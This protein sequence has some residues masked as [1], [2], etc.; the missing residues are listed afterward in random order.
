MTVERKPR[1]APASTTAIG[2]S[3]RR[4]VKN[5]VLEPGTLFH[6]GAII[7]TILWVNLSLGPHP[8]Q[9]DW[10][11]LKIIWNKASH[12]LLEYYQSITVLLLKHLWERLNKYGRPRFSK[13]TWIWKKLTI[14]DT[15]CTLK[16]WILTCHCSLWCF[17]PNKFASLG[18]PTKTAQSRLGWDHC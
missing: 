16:M 11:F 8:E 9:V 4:L 18:E 10:R 6:F 14:L 2:F 5:D 13:S 17:R 1:K 3:W 7:H 15:F 12:R